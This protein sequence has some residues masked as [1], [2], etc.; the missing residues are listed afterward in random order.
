[1]LPCY[2]KIPWLVTHVHL[3]SAKD[4]EYVNRIGNNAINDVFFHQYMIRSLQNWYSLLFETCFTGAECPRNVLFDYETSPFVVLTRAYTSRIWRDKDLLNISF[5]A[6]CMEL[7]TAHMRNGNRAEAFKCA[8]WRSPIQY[9][10]EDI[11]TCM[12]YCSSC[13]IFHL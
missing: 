11:S 13:L 1:M 12:T 7:L 5:I 10:E 3:P 6:S 4:N 8:W 9:S 2:H